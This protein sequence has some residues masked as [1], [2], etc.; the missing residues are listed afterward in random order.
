MQA[1]PMGDKPNGINAFSSRIEH[2]ST[3]EEEQ[4]PMNNTPSSS[5]HPAQ[6]T[7]SYGATQYSSAAL[8]PNNGH[9]HGSIV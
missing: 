9:G 5:T 1:I 4:Q 2:V 6:P 7:Y 8:N 3:N